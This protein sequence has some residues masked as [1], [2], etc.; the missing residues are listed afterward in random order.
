MIDWH[1]MKQQTTYEII[2]KGKDWYYRLR[3]ELEK[4]YNEEDYVAFEVES[5]DYFVGKTG[6]Q[7]L[8]KARR[9][10]PDKQF[11][12]AQVGSVTGLLK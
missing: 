10:Y 7:T 12:L 5:G 1:R 9:K 8:R 2:D 11:F 6:I 3:P 4:N